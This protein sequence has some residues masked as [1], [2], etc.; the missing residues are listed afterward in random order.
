MIAERSAPVLLG[1]VQEAFEHLNHGLDEL[2]LFLVVHLCVAS[3][4]RQLVDALLA[5][6]FLNLLDLVRLETCQ[7]V[8]ESSDEV[9]DFSGEVQV[10]L[11]TLLQYLPH[12]LDSLQLAGHR[13]HV[14]LHFHRR[15]HTGGLREDLQKL[16]VLI[17]L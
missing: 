13:G 5:E 16:R 3:N 11:V 6:L 1:L 17:Y 9:N 12:D 4:C 2:F 10:L 7:V 14:E 15:V 8:I